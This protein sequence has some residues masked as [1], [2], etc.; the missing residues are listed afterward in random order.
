[1]TLTPIAERLAIIFSVFYAGS[2]C[3]QLSLPRRNLKKVMFVVNRFL[4]Y[5]LNKKQLI[6]RIFLGIR[7]FDKN[8]NFILANVCQKLSGK[9]RKDLV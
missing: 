3:F 9:G 7:K 2:V 6:L 1:M 4:F 5:I 8:S